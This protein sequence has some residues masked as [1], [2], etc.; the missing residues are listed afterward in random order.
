MYIYVV[1]EKACCGCLVLV[2]VVAQLYTIV[3]I[4]VCTSLNFG[5]VSNAVPERLNSHRQVNNVQS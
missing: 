5:T 1:S 4:P 2:V 3:V